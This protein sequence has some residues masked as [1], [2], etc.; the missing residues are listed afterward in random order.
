VLDEQLEGRREGEGQ[1]ATDGSRDDDVG[2]GRD[3]QAGRG[4]PGQRADPLHPR[5]G[6]RERQAGGDDRERHAEGE[7]VE[8][9]RQPE[10]GEG[11]ID[12]SDIQPGDVERPCHGDED[13]EHGQLSAAAGIGAPPLATTGQPREQR[14][15]GVEGH[16][17]REAPRLGESFQ[18]EPRHINVEHAQVDRPC[19]PR[20]RLYLRQHGEG[21][22]DHEPVR[23]EDAPGTADGIPTQ[24]GTGLVDHGAKGPGSIEQEPRED[25]EEGHPEV[26]PA[27]QRPDD[28]GEDLGGGEGNMGCQ[29]HEGRDGPIAVEKRKHAPIMSG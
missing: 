8:E 14:Q 9:S 21:E 15:Q 7:P 11:Q 28:G 29:H 16:L 10:A 13:E 2:G 22:H 12:R 25:E 6:I 1:R 23:R 4:I 27:Q 19:R 24:G 20:H 18:G 26:H 3:E 5:R 17:G